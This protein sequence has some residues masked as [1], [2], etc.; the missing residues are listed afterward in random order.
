[1]YKEPG[2]TQEVKLPLSR[3]YNSCRIIEELESPLERRSIS[4]DSEIEKMVPSGILDDPS[5]SN[6]IEKA[7]QEKKTVHREIDELLK[8]EEKSVSDH[9]SSKELPS[10]QP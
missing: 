6:L 8:E 5:P 7:E 3:P 4:E 10:L 2:K 1:M 9:G